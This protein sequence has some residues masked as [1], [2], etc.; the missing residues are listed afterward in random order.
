MKKVAIVALFIFAS[1]TFI[2]HAIII[3]KNEYKKPV[4]INL[5]GVEQEP[6]SQNDTPLL[7]TTFPKKIKI[8]T[9]DSTIYHKGIQKKLLNIYASTQ[10]N[11]SF[12]AIITILDTNNPF[13][14][15]YDTRLFYSPAR[16]I[17]LVNNVDADAFLADQPFLQ[18][19]SDD[20]SDEYI[21]Y[22]LKLKNLNV[23]AYEE[24]QIKG[25]DEDDLPYIK[26]SDQYKNIP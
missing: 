16:A 19:Y 20:D 2:T 25:N 26:F 23:N 1:S 7:L 15:D 22:V 8:R 9:V 3:I 12:N 10:L 17:P 14:F 6:L 4:I 11:P 5:D 18:K 13:F 24:D 21:N